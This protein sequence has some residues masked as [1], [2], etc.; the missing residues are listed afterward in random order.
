MRGPSGRRSRSRK[1]EAV[2]LL[3]RIILAAVFAVA[4]VGKLLDRPG[5]EKAAR[6]FGVPEDW[7]RPLAV[8]LPI[9]ELLIA[10][11]LVPVAT[12]W[13]GAFG[14]L[15]LLAAFTIAMIRQMRQGNAPDCHCF[16]ALHSEPVSPK[17]LVRNV[18]LTLLAL[19]LVVRGWNNQGLGLADLPDALALDLI[20]G[21]AIV[22]LLGAAVY[23]LKTINERQAEIVRRLDVIEW[24]A[25]HEAGSGEIA[26]DGVVNP[27]DGLPIGSPFPDF[28]LPDL[29]GR[30]ISFENLL[31]ELRPMLFFFVSPN[32]AP[33]AALLPEID[34]WRK[35][36][37][38]RVEF[39]FL[40]RG[41]HEENAEKFGA[42]ESQRFLLQNDREVA[43]AVRAQW[44]PTAL[45]VDRNGRINSHLAAGDEAIRE[46]VAQ[47]KA[48]DL[49]RDYVY[50]TARRGGNGR[51][52]KIGESVPEMALRDLDG[53]EIKSADFA[54]RRTLVAFWST[55]CPHCRQM[56]GDLQ[57]WEREKGADEPA[58][59]VFS[60]G[61]SQEHREFGLQSPIVLDEGYR[62][63]QKLG[64]YG[65][66]SAVLVDERGRIASETAVGAP[67]IWALLGKGK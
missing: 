20:F 56:I 2:L 64:M 4:A 57:R 12:A 51:A 29:K 23:Y 38:G 45:F 3:I 49:D 37:A 9:A 41:A 46:L 35:E 60:E 48:A 53:K 1:M 59:L 30:T 17:S 54:G 67:N 13:F 11:L 33:C 58:L 21:L 65:T 63:A 42:D 18:V 7:A 34:A 6:D 52:P 66:P 19:V 44:T 22:A 31:G 28:E 10:L 14:A 26:R 15:A 50:F 62:E 39:V 32:C 5:A 61:D 8:G 43:D 40:S 27:H 25:R 55:S 36:L 24:A 47:I 16:G